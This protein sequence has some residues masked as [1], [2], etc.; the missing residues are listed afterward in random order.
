MQ[1]ANRGRN[2]GWLKRAFRLSTE[3]PIPL[4]HLAFMIV[5]AIP[6]LRESVSPQHGLRSDIVDTGFR[7]NKPDIGI[8]RGLIDQ[9]PDRRS[10][11][12][13]IS[14]C[15]GDSKPDFDTFVRVGNVLVSTQTDN[16]LFN[17]NQVGM[18]TSCVSQCIRNLPKLLQGRQLIDATF[19]QNQIARIPHLAAQPAP[20][21][22]GSFEQTQHGIPDQFM[23]SM[24]ESGKL[25]SSFLARTSP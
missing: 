24:V 10:R 7:E 12:P 18:R 9:Q 1:S 8:T 5:E 11:N 20:V 25:V 16:F 22:P 21:H 17:R 3:I 2:H 14:P 13:A 6:A 23:R 4:D 19:R 15:G